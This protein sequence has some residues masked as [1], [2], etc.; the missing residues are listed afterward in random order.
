MSNT[1]I[2]IFD[3]DAKL[4]HVTSIDTKSEKEH[5]KRLKIIAD[6]LL[7][8][9][10]TY[11]PDLVL[12]EQGF[13]RY[14]GSTEAIYKVFGVVQYLFADIKQLFYPPMTVKKAVLGRGNAPKE[15]VRDV[16]TSFY[17]NMTFN[18]LDETDAAAVGLCHFHKE[19]IL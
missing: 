2:C 17:S 7:E 6:K 9:R 15:A 5:P 14:P 8:L 13:Y 1:G 18:N 4:I 16:I 11:T 3:N 19:G 12:F 10:K